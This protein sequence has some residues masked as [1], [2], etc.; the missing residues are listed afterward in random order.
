MSETS[1][2]SSNTPLDYERPNIVEE[3][4]SKGHDLHTFIY[5]ISRMFE[6]A[7]YY[8]IRGILVLYMIDGALKMG[9]ESAFSV[10]GYF[11]AFIIL[12]QILGAVLGDLVLGNRGALIIGGVLQAIGAFVLCIPSIGALYA[13]M[14]LIVIG[15]GLYSPNLLASFGKHYLNKKHLLDAGFGIIYTAVNM[16]AFL[17]IA[18]LS[19]IAE[20]V[21]YPIGFAC[22]GFL[23][24]VAAILPLALRGQANFRNVQLSIPLSNR[25]LK[26]VIACIA[27]G[28][29]WGVY[30]ISYSDL[31]E[32]FEQLSNSLDLPESMARSVSTIF[33]LPLIV[34]AVIIW[35]I[36]RQGHFVKLFIGFVSG[37]IGLGLIYLISG[38]IS[39]SDTF[40]VLLAA[41]F[42]SLAEIHIAPIAYSI[43]TRYAHPKY[44]AMILSLLLVASSMAYKIVSLLAD[45]SQFYRPSFGSYIGAIT[46]LIASVGLLIYLL[47]TRKNEVG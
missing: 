37:A 38:S 24:L 19:L 10:Y 9:Q 47:T 8:G 35:S 28:I 36:F 21:G 5:S 30:E 18:V 26:I 1:Y 32:G 4:S 16:G 40:I 27:A 22:G 14:V 43:L 34:I 46:M 13:G 45:V 2:S 29:F 17:G 11:T 42:F 39:D 23:M 12:A 6:R 15:G 3:Q 33:L 41:F 31:Y 7:A 25:V 44:L 20:K